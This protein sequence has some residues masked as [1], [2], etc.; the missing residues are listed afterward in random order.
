MTLGDSHSLYSFA[1]V[2]EAKIYWRGPVTM[3]RAARDGIASLLPKNCRPKAGDV[4]ILSLGEIDS[5]V[6]VP[7]I[8]RLNARSSL[9]EA[10]ALLGRFE[11]AL[12]H[13]RAKCPATV[14]LASLVP[15][16]PAYLEYDGYENA[17]ACRADTKAVRDRMNARMA[18]MGVPFVDFHDGYANADGSIQPRFSD[19][20]VH[21]DPRHSEPVLAAL[22]ETFGREF[23]SR[24]PPWPPD[25]LAEKPYQSPWKRF[26]RAVRA[27][28]KAWLGIKPTPARTSPVTQRENP[29]Q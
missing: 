15:F 4:L 26:R 21:I 13:F 3:H 19:N 23:T 6:H 22:R 29:Q 9:E 14:A 24:Q 25:S 10:E 5:R 11:V 7:R 17:E 16:N 28:V 18:S 12:K 20:N 8:A 2:A 27:K 1:G